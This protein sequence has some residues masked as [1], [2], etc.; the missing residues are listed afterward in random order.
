MEAETRILVLED[1]R[2]LRIL[3]GEVFREWGMLSL[4]VANG[5]EALAEFLDDSFDVALIDIHVP[6]ASGYEIIDILLSHG[7]SPARIIVMSGDIDGIELIRKKVPVHTL[8]KPFMLDDLRA[9]I[10]DALALPPKPTDQ[11]I[12]FGS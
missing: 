6:M 7:F 8:T 4:I 12:R 3:F 2:D 5:T 9:V 10:L 11:E 1:E